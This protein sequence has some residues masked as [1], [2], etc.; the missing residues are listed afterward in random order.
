MLKK[1]I[2]SIKF[3]IL[4]K[5]YLFEFDSKWCEQLPIFCGWYLKDI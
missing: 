1:L 4:I 3:L 5:F 2:I